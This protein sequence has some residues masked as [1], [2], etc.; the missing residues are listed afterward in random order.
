MAKWDSDCR[1]YQ[2]A[3]NIVADGCGAERPLG[4]AQGSRC[5]QFGVGFSEK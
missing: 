3:D 4:H 5:E 2:T 1:G